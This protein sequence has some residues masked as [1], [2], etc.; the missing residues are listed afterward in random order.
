[1]KKILV[2][3]DDISIL[4]MVQLVLEDEGYNV[5]TSLNGACFLHMN[6]DLPDLILLDLK[7]PRLDGFE[8]LQWIRAQP[9]I[10]GIPVIVLTSSNL[11][12][13]VNRAYN[14]GATTLTAGIVRYRIY[15]AW[16]LGILDVAKMGFVTG[17][18]FWLDGRALPS[19]RSEGPDVADW[20]ARSLHRSV[21]VDLQHD[22]M[23]E[24]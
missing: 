15:S 2:V 10:R 24:L 21:S 18:T 20:L 3:D 1:M 22:G 23:T 9:G 6:S 14:L 5:Q 19:G 16:S 13:D 12:K 4:G 7:M 8:V 11:I 17:L